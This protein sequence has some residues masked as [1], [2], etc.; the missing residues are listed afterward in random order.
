[1][2]GLPT[3]AGDGRGDSFG[4]RLR[5]A[6]E[7]AGLAQ[8]ELAARAG[9]SPNVVGGLERGEH[10]HPY[11]ATVRALAA[12]LGLTDDE[13]A[14]LAAAVPRRGHGTAANA[15]R[16]DLPAPLSS[17]VGRERELADVSAMLRGDRHAQ[18]GAQRAPGTRLVTLTGPGGVGKTRLALQVAAE[19]AGEFANG[20]AFV[21]LAAVRDPALVSSTIAYVLGVA[22]GGGRVPV[23]RLGDALRARH[24]LLVLDNFEQVVEAAALVTDLLVRCPRL[25]VLVTSRAALRLESERVYP[26]PPLVVPDPEHLPIVERLANVAAVR[27]FVDRAR[28]VDPAFGLTDGNAGA[29]AAVCHRLD[30]LPLAIELAA[31]RSTLFA[32]D[33]M[34]PR[35]ARRLPLLTGGRR[36]APARHRTMRDAIAWSHDLLSDDEQTLFRRLAVFVGGFTLE[37]AEYVSRETGDGS[38]E[39]GSSTPDSRLPSPVSVLDGIAALLDASL[40]RQ[41]PGPDDE[42]R[43][44]MLETVREYGLERLAEAGEEA[45][46]RD[47]HA[48]FFVG[49]DE[50]LDPNIT[51]PGERV[52]DRLWRIEGEHPNLRAALAHLAET[53]DAAGVLRLAGA[54]AV[55]WHHRG[56]LEEGRRWLE[57]AL[58]QTP[59]SPT[60]WRARAL[61][62]LSL[63]LWSQ[64]DNEGAG[65]FAEAG[66]AAAEAVDDKELIALS[67]HLL[68]IVEL[69]RGRLER[70]ERLMN[71]TL[72]LQRAIGWVSSGSMALMV[73]SQIAY[74]A[75]DAGLAARRAEEALAIF[76]ALGH[77]SAAASTLG[78]LARLALDRGDDQAAVQSYHEMLRLLSAVDECYA[79][80]G[81]AGAAAEAPVFPR[82][83]SVD[84][85]RTVV[86]ALVGLARIA[87]AHGRPEQAAT[88]AGAV[89]LRIGEMGT[90]LGPA[91]RARHDRTVAATRAAV[92]EERFAEWHAAGRA[93]TLA[94]AVALAMEVT[95][96]DP[97]AEAVGESPSRSG[98]DAL[99]ARERDVLRLLVEGRSN[100]EIAA[101]L[102]VGAGT[103]KTHVA[104]ILAKLGVPT[105]A[106]AATHAVRHGFV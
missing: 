1:M 62:G 73:L 23:D 31:A 98:V 66:L 68:G 75:G 74:R 82:W 36:D 43:L 77:P 46:A 47:V 42:P 53:G 2:G 67:I 106:A 56:H 83:T 88:L 94:A 4:A 27:L 85:R 40:L 89:D 10:R 50:R 102:F 38:R 84:D 57:W 95:A 25:V 29:V 81:A 48:A 6:R 63:I 60:K 71:E 14:A 87:D 19:L 22:E 20:T 13:R 11:P 15:A 49:W 24:L 17:L 72:G 86:L 8:E 7:A 30:G 101:A 65:S 52:E 100:A 104:N 33:A 105:R 55:F 3:S 18:G 103:V 96:L 44:S 35:L 51:A 16:A 41:V 78:V 99:T 21:S 45:R 28:A 80:G 54:L 9:L 93:L 32:P 26:V 58:A 92:G 90:Q 97:R 64:G 37:A 34:L 76:Q 61:A 91:D 79:A 12:A 59:D 5:R 70:A 69:V 39:N